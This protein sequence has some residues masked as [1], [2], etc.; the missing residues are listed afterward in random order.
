MAKKSDDSSFKIVDRRPFAAD[1][2]ARSEPP[3]VTTERPTSARKPEAEAPV[4]DAP[5]DSAE[6][7]P[8]EDFSFEGGAE[9]GDYSGFE[10]LV[11]YLGTTAMFQLGLVAGPTGQRLPADLLNA[12]STIDMLE[13][14][15]HKTRG[16]LTPD[17]GRLLEDVLYEL[18]LAF[19]EVERRAGAK[20]K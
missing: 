16:N 5:K 18:R 3:E 11:S 15:E 6:L 12:R 20:P 13:V 14:L 19:V 1:G 10:T 2:S 9:A 7:E 8:R 4:S 17:E